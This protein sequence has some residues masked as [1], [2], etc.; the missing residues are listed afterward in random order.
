MAD[1]FQNVDA[2]GEEFI[3]LFADSMDVRQSDPTMESV[4]AHYLKHLDLGP[5]SLTIEI[6]AGAGAV[7]RR[8]AAASQGQV[9]GFEPSTGFV[10]EARKRAADI[11][12]VRFDVADGAAL[13]LDDGI[14]DGVVIHTVLTHVTEPVALVREA[15]RVLKPGGTLAV[16][17]IDF[18]KGTLASFVHDPLDACAQTFTS[19]FVTDKYLVGKLRALLQSEG[20]EVTHF[21]MDSRVVTTPEQM[22]PWVVMSTQVMVDRGDIGQGLADALVAEYNRR[23]EAGS[24]YGYQAVATAVAG[25]P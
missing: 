11:P 24:L 9:I 8:I 13:P 3:S 16:C 18:S 22:M 12:N 20:L 14:A 17:D 4:V 1:P 25:K 21:G 15:V 7:T 5:Q 23:A 10:A 6:G 2:A 19:H